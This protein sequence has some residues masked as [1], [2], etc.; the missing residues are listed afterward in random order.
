M[1]RD[2]DGERFLRIVGKRQRP[3]PGVLPSPAARRA[4]G[5]M[6]AYRTRAPKGIFLYRSHDEANRDRD[7]WLMDAMAEK[8]RHG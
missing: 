6:A 8:Q 4:M 2:V 5:E 7:L 1:D 3:R